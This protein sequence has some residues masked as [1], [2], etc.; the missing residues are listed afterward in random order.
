MAIPRRT[1]FIVLGSIVGLILLIGLCVPLFLDADSFRNRIESTL[2]TSLG[3]KVTLGKLDLS[4]FSGSLVAENTTLADDPA[5]STQPFMTVSKVKIGI[6]MIPL[7]LSREIHITGF[8]LD[9]PKINLLRAA[10]GTWNYSTIGSAQKNAPA[11]ESNSLIPNL[12]VGHVTVKDGQLTVGALPAAGAPATPQHT[13]DKL[14]L[15]A[16]D[17]SF[18]K[19]FPFTASTNLPNG[20]TVSLSGNAGPIDAKDASLTP[21]SAHLVVKHL[22]PLAA[23]FV[24][25]TAGVTG[26]IDAIDVQA[27]GTGVNS[28]S[29]ISSSIHPSSPSSARTNPP[30]SQPRPPRPTATTC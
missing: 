4:V 9:S 20:G 18:A 26:T 23:G 10:N 30:T 1:L 5:F 3:R 25:S 2:S 19:S 22:D 7:I 27:T 14:E 24:D 8:A 17:F 13:Y 29:P 15:D 11:K 28:T 12:T 6:E 21:F 16:K